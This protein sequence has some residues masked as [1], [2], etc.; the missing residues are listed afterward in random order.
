M[1]SK[2]HQRESG[3]HDAP[4]TPANVSITVPD[5][6]A[7]MMSDTFA[8]AWGRSSPPHPRRRLL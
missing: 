1:V 5:T 3:G 2:N 8:G 6:E 4:Q 7:A